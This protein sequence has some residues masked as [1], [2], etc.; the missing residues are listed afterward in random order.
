MAEIFWTAEAEADFL[1]L[2]S[3]AQQVIR[4]RV[5]ILKQFPMA[6]TAMSDRWKGFRKL[7][8]RPWWIVYT[9]PSPNKVIVAYLLHERTDWQRGAYI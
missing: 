4:R 3:K 7:Y 2:D 1:T 9:V 8:A 5:E 6:G